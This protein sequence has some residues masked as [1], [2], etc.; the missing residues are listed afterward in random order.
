MVLTCVFFFFVGGTQWQHASPEAPI[1]WSSGGSGFSWQF[2]MP[3]YQTSQVES[4]LKAQNNS[5]GFPPPGTFNAAGRA[6]PD[7]AALADGIPMV[8][9]GSTVET[10]GTSGT[11][12]F[13]N[14]FLKN[15]LHFVFFL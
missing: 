11:S 6:Y 8:E 3:S 15:S 13:P 14:V 1:A 10:G 5:Q 4:Y 7:V 12:V 9:Q 2:D